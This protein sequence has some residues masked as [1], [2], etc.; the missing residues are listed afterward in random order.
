M[1]G[2][3]FNASLPHRLRLQGLNCTTPRDRRD[4]RGLPPPGYHQRGD[5]LGCGVS[6]IKLDLSL[7][8][9]TNAITILQAAVAKGDANSAN[10][11]TLLNLIQAAQ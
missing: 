6:Y 4:Q 11:Q 2:T 1:R 5:Q 3:K 10:A 8:D 9:K 7:T